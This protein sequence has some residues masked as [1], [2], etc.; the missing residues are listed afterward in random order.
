MLHTAYPKGKQLFGGPSAAA[1]FRAEPQA[2]E[3][4]GSTHD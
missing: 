3:R 4:V 2:N 1:S